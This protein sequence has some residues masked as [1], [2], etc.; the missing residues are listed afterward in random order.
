MKTITITINRTLARAAMQ[1]LTDANEHAE[2]YTPDPKLNA[3]LHDVWLETC[4]AD[5]QT[6]ANY[7]VLALSF[8]RASGLYYYNFLTNPIVYMEFQTDLLKNPHEVG[9]LFLAVLFNQI[10]EALDKPLRLKLPDDAYI[11]SHIETIVGKLELSL[12]SSPSKPSK[13]LEPLEMLF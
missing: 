12:L 7:E 11:P 2:Q 10:A 3:F 13:P 6:W 4:R 1:F 8:P 9:M 5:D